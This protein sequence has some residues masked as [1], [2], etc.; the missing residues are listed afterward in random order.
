GAN[1]ILIDNGSA[2]NN[3]TVGGSG[4]GIYSIATQSTITLDNQSTIDN[5]TAANDGGG[6]YSIALTSSTIT[7]DNASSISGNKATAGSGGAI[8]NY[9]KDNATVEILGDSQ[10]E[11][12]L[13]TTINNNI[14]NTHGGAIYNVSMVNANVLVGTRYNNADKKIDV[15]TTLSTNKATTGSGGAIYNVARNVGADG[16]GVNLQNVE[17]EAIVTIQNADILNNEAATSGGGIYNL[18]EAYNRAKIDTAYGADPNYTTSHTTAN[19]FVEQYSMIS[20]NKATDGAGIYNDSY[21]QSYNQGRQ[22]YQDGSYS[23][24]NYSKATADS[25]VSVW[26]STLANNEATGKGGAIYNTPRTG[27][28]SIKTNNAT[29]HVQNATLSQNKADLGA[30]VYSSG[31]DNADITIAN[32]TIAGN[33]ASSNG[34]GFYI[35]DTTSKVLLLNTIVWTNYLGTASN[36]IVFVNA[37]EYFHVVYSIYGSFIG[38]EQSNKSVEDLQ[39]NVQEYTV[40]RMFENVRQDEDG[41]WVA[42]LYTT[43]PRGDNRTIRITSRGEAVYKGTF[44][45]LVE[46]DDQSGIK[47]IYYHDI[48]NVKWKSLTNDKVYEFNRNVQQYEKYGLPPTL[49]TLYHDAQNIYL[50]IDN[51]TWVPAPRFTGVNF[52]NVGAY[53]LYDAYETASLHVTTEEDIIDF[54]DGWISLR[55]ALVYAASG[56]KAT[57]KVNGEEL[58]YDADKYTI[59]FADNEDIWVRNK[60]TGELELHEGVTVNTIVLNPEYDEL[61]VSNG[62]SN[63]Q[64]KSD[65]NPSGPLSNIFTIAGRNQRGDIHGTHSGGEKQVTVKVPVTYQE[66]LQSGEQAT[67]FRVMRIGSNQ[68]ANKIWRVNFDNLDLR[69][70]SIASDN[71]SG[72]GGTIFARGSIVQ[73]GFDKVRIAESKARYG[74]GLYVYATNIADSK[75]TFTNGSTIENNI[76]T[77]HGGGIYTRYVNSE[78]DNTT[79]QN[80]EAVHGGGIYSTSTT[81]SLKFVNSN[82]LNNTATNNGGGIYSYGSTS[83]IIS[84]ENDPIAEDGGRSIIRGNAAVNGGAIYSQSNQLSKIT[85]ISSDIIS[86]TATNNGGAIYS[87]GTTSSIISIESDPTATDGGRSIIRGNAAVNGGAIYSYSNRSSEITIGGSDVENNEASGSGGFIYNYVETNTPSSVNVAATATVKIWNHS[88]MTNNTA[89]GSGGTIYNY[90]Y[91]YNTLNNGSNNIYAT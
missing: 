48:V 10:H 56:T 29:I 34:A 91:S 54:T 36:D 63:I 3:N 18:A 84:I 43:D 86:N 15:R 70:G 73:L 83:S 75:L 27:S 14:A 66:S 88:I 24:L 53:S 22:Y 45:A 12:N 42:D 19:V 77:T 79:L 50:K 44:L 1:T 13:Y 55:E 37:P 7:V 89:S 30:G 32:A 64:V 11:A 6:I 41:R 2:I 16:L 47:D 68:D 90:A 25:T 23:L 85:I 58:H 49:S 65:Q 71:Q 78:F 33:V 59:T 81:S 46:R 76:A 8:Y 87:I 60:D 82:I 4:G 21:S 35:E 51:N 26:D 31:A 28:A 20:G 40:K 61:V 62:L 52:Y 72:A 57:L 5:N 39:L 74:G 80:N 9:A 17:V 69:G 67:N 38:A